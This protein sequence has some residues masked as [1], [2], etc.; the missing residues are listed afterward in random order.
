MDAC[1]PNATILYTYYEIHR[2]MV[3]TE[4]S[5]KRDRK[6]GYEKE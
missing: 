6:L 5:K 3:G 2:E 4:D 1:Y